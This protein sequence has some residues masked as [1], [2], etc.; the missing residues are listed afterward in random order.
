MVAGDGSM[1]LNIQEL[2]TV[3]HARLPIKMVV[4]D[5]RCHGM[6]RQFQETY[7][8]GRYPSTWW[9]YSAPDFA[10]V[11]TAYGIG[12]RRVEDPDGLE[13]ALAWLWE[14]P[15]APSLLHVPIDPLANAYPKLAFGRPMTEMEPLAEPVAMGSA[16][17]AAIEG[18]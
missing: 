7:F 4:L 18:T 9:G 17:G 12:S 8:E 15:E 3:A 2:E 1:Q 16:A 13:A 6:V 10:A 11:A 14:D 5:N